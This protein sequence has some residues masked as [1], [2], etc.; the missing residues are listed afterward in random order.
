MNTSE[1]T[2]KLMPALLAARK[3]MSPA[4]KDKRNEHFRYSYAN[5]EAWHEAVQPYLLENNLMLSFSCDSV[6]R[7]ETTTAKGEKSGL[8]TVQGCARVT[9]ISGEFLEICG[10]GE[11]A[12]NSDKGAYKAQTGLK[13]YLYA[14]LF[15]LPTTDDPEKDNGLAA[16][17]AA[18]SP[19]REHDDRT[20][21]G[22]ANRQLDNAARIPN[23]G[24]D[25]GRPFGATPEPDDLAIPGMLTFEGLLA[26]AAKPKENKNKPGT[27]RYG[28]KMPDGEWLN[29]FDQEVAEFLTAAGKDKKPVTITYEKG[30]YGNDIVQAMAG[31]IQ[32]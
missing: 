17:D 31:K 5:E 3:A 13:K 24:G 28:F 27:Y 20:K 19:A 21:E 16:P 12:D 2:T 25:S 7:V 8:T 14:L 11:G 22:R 29:T 10:C 15:A 1:T 4:Y 26:A 6:S 9:H 18:A 30:K 32:F 23:D